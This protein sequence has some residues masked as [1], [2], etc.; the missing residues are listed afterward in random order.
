MKESCISVK[1][2]LAMLSPANSHARADV[3]L[4]GFPP[5]HN[6]DPPNLVFLYLSV[7]TAIL[8]LDWPPQIRQHEP[9]PQYGEHRSRRRLASRAERTLQ[10]HIPRL[11]RDVHS[12]IKRR[13]LLPA[14]NPTSAADDASGMVPR[15][16]ILAGSLI[17]EDTSMSEV[18]RRLLQ[19]TR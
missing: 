13:Y 8:P 7:P 11:Q 4:P 3:N 17:D 1:R 19:P 2:C 15:K 14:F 16:Y 12:L 9:G 10:T 5:P 18:T 6:N